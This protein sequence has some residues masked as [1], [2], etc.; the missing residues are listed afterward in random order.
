[1]VGKAAEATGV[2]REERRQVPPARPRPTV[3]GKGMAD[4][5]SP[6]TAASEQRLPEILSTRDGSD[7]LHNH[8]Q[9]V[10]ILTSR[11]P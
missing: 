11:P 2:W 10:P 6:P 9:N 1:M 4:G 5:S 3:S 7:S 8:P